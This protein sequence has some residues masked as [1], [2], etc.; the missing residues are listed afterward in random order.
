MMGILT[1]DI[2]NQILARE[3]LTCG[4]NTSDSVVHFGSGYKELML[5]NYLLHL[6]SQNLIGDISLQ[7]T[8]VDPEESVNQSI[9]DL[10]DTKSFGVK[11]ETH[12]QSTQEFL[13]ENGN[14]YD[15]SVI[16]GLFD[17]N[18]Y[19]DKQFQF[20][21][22]IIDSCFNISNQGVVFTFDVSKE[23]DDTYTVRHII[24]YIESKFKRYRINK[25]NEKFYVMCI[26]RHFYSSTN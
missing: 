14:T 25:I 13:D 10:G 15:W 1:M 12:T 19:G 22:R 20:L 8:S 11:I 9:I 7:Y 23:N 5:Y 6:N 16:T 2:E 21:D 17:K 24:S 4:I 18:L 3:I 26:Y